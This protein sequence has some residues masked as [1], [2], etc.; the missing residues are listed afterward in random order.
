M[1]YTEIQDVVL[2]IKLWAIGANKGG[3]LLRL[4]S[5]NAT[6]YYR[7]HSLICTI[8]LT[9]WR[10]FMIIWRR[11]EFYCPSLSII[12]FGRRMHAQ[13]F[14]FLLDWDPIYSDR[15]FW[16]I[17]SDFRGCRIDFIIWMILMRVDFECIIDSIWSYNL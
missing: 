17:K 1:L 4:I 8:V 7:K 16:R 9:Y 15:Q 3:L 13:F 12:F 5:R 14:F 2:G 11:I 6:D 10:S